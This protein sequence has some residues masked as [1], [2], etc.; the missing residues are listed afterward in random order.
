M[1]L[2]L[3]THRFAGRIWVICGL[4]CMVCGLFPDAPVATILFVALV[5]AAAL[6]PCAYSYRYYKAQ[7]QDGRAIP[8]KIRWKI[9]L[10]PSPP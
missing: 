7:L 1:S 2:L 6:I 9:V 8:T 10:S 4:L 5:L 3:G